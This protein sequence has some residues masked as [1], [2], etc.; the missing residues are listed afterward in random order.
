MKRFYR[1]ANVYVTGARAHHARAR[2]RAHLARAS[3]RAHH[4]RERAHHAR[5]RAHH[6][7]ERAHHARARWGA[8]ELTTAM[9][10]RAEHET[11]AIS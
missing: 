2:E 6:A 11:H 8:I 7:R 10:A 9:R 4:A 1:N 5:E 3:E